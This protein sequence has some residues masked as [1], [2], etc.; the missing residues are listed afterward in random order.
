MRRRPL[1]AAVGASCLALG[2]CLDGRNGSHP[3]E[4]V[5]STGDIAVVIDNQRDERATVTVTIT[6]DTATVFEDSVTVQAGEFVRLDPGL[7]EPGSGY[8]LIAETQEGRRDDFP[9]GI[10]EYDLQQGSNLLVWL[11]D[12]R[13]RTGMEE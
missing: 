2:G 9:F 12:G 6:A 5:D 4:T 1:L 11:S 8:E 10:E 7:H 3:T 13:V